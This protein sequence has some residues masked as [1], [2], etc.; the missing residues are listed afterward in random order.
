MHSDCVSGQ[1]QYQYLI[2]DKLTVCEICTYT[3]ATDHSYSHT[4]RTLA[5]TSSANCGSMNEA[6]WMVGL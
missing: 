4:L 3:L 6:L 5:M 1:Y 2:T